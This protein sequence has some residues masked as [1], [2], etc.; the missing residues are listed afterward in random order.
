MINLG[1]VV[2][3]VHPF[4]N[5]QWSGKP[6]G[7]FLHVLDMILH[8]EPGQCVEHVAILDDGS[9][10]PLYNLVEIDVDI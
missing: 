6:M 1:A 8:K 9:K 7:R 3:R 2:K 4:D 5:S 10:E